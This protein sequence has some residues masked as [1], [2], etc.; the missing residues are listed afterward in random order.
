MDLERT[1]ITGWSFGGYLSALAAL[2]RSR[3]FQG[4]R[5]RCPGL[6]W[7]DYDTHYTEGDLGLP[8]KDEPAYKEASLLTYAKDSETAA[9]ADARHG[10]RQRLLSAL[11][12]AGRRPVPG[13]ART[14]RSCRCRA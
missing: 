8:E 5:G 4:R 7:D 11:A 13:R 1:G 12:Q 9:A 2:R 6:D 14:S 10:R 3:R